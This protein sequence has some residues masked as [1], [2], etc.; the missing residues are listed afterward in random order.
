MNNDELTPSEKKA[1]E[2]LPKWRHPHPSLEQRTVRALRIRGILRERRSFLIELT[3]VRLA[4]AVAASIV[5]LICAFSLG[6]W[7]KSVPV[8]ASKPISLK[9]TG[10]QNSRTKLIDSDFSEFQDIYTKDGKVRV[11][12]FVGG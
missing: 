9:D 8:S 2:S 4:T 11:I 10:L 12:K 7:L 5:L 1:F 6:Y 3:P